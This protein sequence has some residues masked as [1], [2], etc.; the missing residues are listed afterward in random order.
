MRG[1]C[2]MSSLFC[3]LQACAANANSIHFIAKCEIRFD[4]ARWMVRLWKKKTSR[5]KFMQHAISHEGYSKLKYFLTS[6]NSSMV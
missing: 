6:Y 5:S 1:L 3:H 4:L 2:Q